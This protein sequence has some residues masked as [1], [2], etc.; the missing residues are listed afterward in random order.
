MKLALRFAVYGS[1]I[2]A[3]FGI[4]SMYWLAGTAIAAYFLSIYEESEDAPDGDF[5]NLKS[6]QFLASDNNIKKRLAVR[7][8]Y[9]GAVFLV[10]LGFS[11]FLEK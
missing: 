5:R 6:E 3:G 1:A 11:Y 7:F 8:V 10:C 9:A 4:I 2:S